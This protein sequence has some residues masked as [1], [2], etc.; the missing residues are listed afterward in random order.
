MKAAL[1]ILFTIA[2][3]ATIY[4]MFVRPLLRQQ[5][6]LQDFWRTTD[7]LELSIWK[8][9]QVFFEGIKIKLLARIV[10]VPTLITAVYDK[11]AEICASCDLTPIT[12]ALPEDIKGWLP[13][14]SAIGVPILIDWARSYSSSEPPAG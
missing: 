11:F 1:L 4:L 13:L 2:S 3:T 8:K 12:A 6:S 10:W 5:A 14:I 7:A 9:T